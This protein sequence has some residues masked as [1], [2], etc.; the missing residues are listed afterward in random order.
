[1]LQW[2]FSHEKRIR[3]YL[4]ERKRCNPEV[5]VVAGIEI[6][7]TLTGVIPGGASGRV[8]GAVGSR[9]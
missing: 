6:C 4:A 2:D 3:T 9:S 1:M 7:D 5:E 8:G